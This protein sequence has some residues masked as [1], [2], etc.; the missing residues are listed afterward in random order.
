MS[1]LLCVSV[2]WATT[3]FLFMGLGL[4]A[5]LLAE[6]ASDSSHAMIADD[7]T[8]DHAPRMASV[9]LAISERQPVQD[10]REYADTLNGFVQLDGIVTLA[11]HDS[12]ASVADHKEHTGAVIVRD[13]RLIRARGARNSS[14]HTGAVEET[15]ARISATKKIVTIHEAAEVLAPEISYH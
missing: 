11:S 5:L 14:G 6:R 7:G 9:D 13:P 15:V 10:A 1:I 8:V 4:V 2:A 12:H 3:G